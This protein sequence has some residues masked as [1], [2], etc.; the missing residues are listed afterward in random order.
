ML[1]YST[2]WVA[3]LSLAFPYYYR[4]EQWKPPRIQHCYN[5]CMTDARGYKSLINNSQA[6]FWALSHECSYGVDEKI[7]KHPRVITFPA[8]KEKTV[9]WEKKNMKQK[10]SCCFKTH[11]VSTCQ[12]ILGNATI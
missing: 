12:C 6:Q 10:T 3:T 11:S 1:N 4:Y 8:Q 9:L 7:A 2:H 5:E